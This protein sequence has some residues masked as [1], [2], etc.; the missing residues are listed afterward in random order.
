MKDEKFKNACVFAVCIGHIGGTV[1]A[2]KDYVESGFNM[3][4]KEF[5]KSYG[6]GFAIG[7]TIGAS[8]GMLR[9]SEEKEN[10]SE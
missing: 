9:K 6:R 4:W 1:T 3:S 2:I 10:P 8:G 7:A 5:G